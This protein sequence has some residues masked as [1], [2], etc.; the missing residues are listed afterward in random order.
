MKYILEKIVPNVQTSSRTSM[1]TLFAAYIPPR[2]L[3]TR[4]NNDT[5]EFSVL[6]TSPPFAAGLDLLRPI[7][8]YP[9]ITHHHRPSSQTP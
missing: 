5:R 9:P 2:R 3:A 4:S 1:R 7:S 6:F 8:P